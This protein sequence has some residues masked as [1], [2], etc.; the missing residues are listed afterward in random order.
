MYAMKNKVQLIGTVETAQIEI[1]TSGMKKADF[2]VSTNEN[3][4]S[5]NGERI[6]LQIFHSCRAFG[7]LADIVEKFVSKGVE[8]AIEGTLINEFATVIIG[9]PLSETVIQISDILILSV[10]NHNS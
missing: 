3:F 9:K 6:S 5:R 4:L 1:L 8:V 7:N 2:I 10:R